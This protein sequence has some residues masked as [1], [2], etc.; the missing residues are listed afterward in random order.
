MTY[1]AQY[2]DGLLYQAGGA[3]ATAYCIA[4]LIRLHRRFDT[5]YVKNPA[6]ITRTG[7]A[8][9]KIAPSGFLAKQ[10]NRQRGYPRQGVHMLARSI[11]PPTGGPYARAAGAMPPE[12]TITAAHTSGNTPGALKPAFS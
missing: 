10:R 4:A 1:S 8:F 12:A 9:R 2:Q 11:S 7:K 5:A 6:L 3:I